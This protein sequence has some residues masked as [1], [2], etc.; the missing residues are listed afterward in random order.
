MNFEYVYDYLMD[1]AVYDHWF[2]YASS[3]F[4]KNDQPILDLACGSGS[5]TVR[6][7][8]ASYPV[9]GLDLSDHMLARAQNRAQ[10]AGVKIKWIQADMSAIPD[11]G[12]LSGALCSLD[13]L[14]YLPY[15]ENVLLVFEAVYELLDQGSYF[16]FD[17]HTPWKMTHGYQDY[18]YNYV[19]EDWAFL[20]QSYPADED[21]SVIHQL[22]LFVKQ[23]D[24]SYRRQSRDI[25]QVTHP[26]DTYLKLLN[27]VG[28]RELQVTSDFGQSKQVDQVD[29]WFFACRK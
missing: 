4:D 27:H 6:L 22:D 13:A 24:S 7:K 29:R 2:D 23:E 17:V 16:L 25:Y 19:E 14:C 20:W 3:F 8:Q 21:Y 10:Q 5:L 9:I 11:L 1:E 26:L 12:P 28:F 15:L 18:V